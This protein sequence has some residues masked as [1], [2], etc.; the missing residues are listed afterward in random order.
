MDWVKHIPP[1]VWITVLPLILT[2]VGTDIK[3]KDKNDTGA[4]DFFGQLLIEIS[5]AI[6]AYQLGQGTAVQKAVRIVR[7]RCNKYL[8]E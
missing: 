2:M 6:V 1:V 4:D 8:G 3:N 7:D 5:P